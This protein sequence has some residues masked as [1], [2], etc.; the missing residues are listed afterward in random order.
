VKEKKNE[1]REDGDKRVEKAGDPYT[2]VLAGK[3][4]RMMI[5]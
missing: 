4:Y 3:S 1:A 5:G 2:I